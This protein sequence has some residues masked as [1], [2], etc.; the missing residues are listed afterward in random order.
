[1]DTDKIASERARVAAEARTWLGTPYHSKAS[2]RGAGVDCAMLPARVY[3]AAGVLEEVNPEYDDQWFLH[4]DEEKYLAWVK[5]YCREITRAELGVGDFI[6]WRFGRTFSHGAIL[7]ELPSTIIHATHADE[8][9]TTDDMD[10]NE[11]LR[12]RPAL[13]FSPWGR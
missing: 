7:L 10:R 6:I 3:Q 9:V 13:Y 1:M 12:T 5:P 2:V 8:C 11:E 4:H